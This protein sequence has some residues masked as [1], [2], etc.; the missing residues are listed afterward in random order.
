MSQSTKPAIKNHELL[1]M[2][3]DMDREELIRQVIALYDD[4][5]RLRRELDE[6]QGIV[7]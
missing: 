1:P 7:R 6:A 4:C 3:L 5:A 2:L